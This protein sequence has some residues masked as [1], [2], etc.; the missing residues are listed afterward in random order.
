MKATAEVLTD[1]P[2]QFHGLLREAADDTKGRRSLQQRFA[3][4]YQRLMGQGAYSSLMPPAARS[5]LIE[6]LLVHLDETW[7]GEAALPRQLVGKVGSGQWISRSRAALR[8]GVHENTILKMVNSG[9]IKGQF[10]TAGK[11]TYLF[12][13]K[14]EVELAETE[15]L[16]HLD[17]QEFKRELDAI[18][19]GDAAQL[20]GVNI[21]HVREL[22]RVGLVMSISR[23][24]KHYVSRRSLEHL[25]DRVE[26]M[27][28]ATVKEKTNLIGVARVVQVYKGLG[29]AELLNDILDGK[30]HVA[31]IISSEFG[32]R[33]FLFNCDA[34][35]LLAQERRASQGTMT[36]AEVRRALQCGTL[37]IARLL[38]S[39]FL[40]DLQGSGPQRGRHR[41]ITLE[42]VEI[43]DRDFVP[44]PVL[45]RAHRIHAYKIVNL[46]H[47]HGV[48]PILPA[49]G[50]NTRSF[51]RRSE[52]G[53]VLGTPKHT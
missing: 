32:F 12:V 30:V 35:A 39:G 52:V 50:E 16:P 40:V 19:F 3:G 6:E 51:W 26:C 41:K 5:V 48:E 49:D 23:P 22:V 27:P 43:F 1:W 11:I 20:S 2:R 7:I 44:L 31:S 33:R 9:Q 21:D 45:A 4:L 17:T 25:I 34:V 42:S 46:L 13:S 28:Q 8:M 53:S 36:A 24:P 10:V 15:R 14:A 38:A 29:I 18:T 37:D 47:K